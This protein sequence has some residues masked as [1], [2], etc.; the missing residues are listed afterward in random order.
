MVR[1]AHISDLHLSKITFCPSQFLSKRWLGNMNLIFFRRKKFRPE[2]LSLLPDLF[3]KH[4]IDY[5]IVSGDISST[6]LKEEFEMGKIIFDELLKKKITPLFLPGNHDKYTKGSHTTKRFYNYFENKRGSSKIEKAFSLKNDEV[7]A[8]KLSE[9]WWY[10]GIDCAIATH[11]LSSRGLFSKK[12]EK[13]LKALLAMIPKEQNIIMVGHF[14]LTQREGPRRSLK[15]SRELKEII[16]THSNIKIYLHGHTHRHFILDLRHKQLPLILDSG[17][18]A[19]N[20]IGKWN[21][22]NLE[23]NS[24]HISIFEWIKEKHK[25][26]KNRR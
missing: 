20:A 11:L 17:S 4:K 16:K 8:H 15:R 6:S 5:S 14:P 7:E 1:I 26:E 23:K 25:W 2:Q 13:N 22:L 9:H 19:H 24:C 18:T 10:V 3:E 21:L 12:A